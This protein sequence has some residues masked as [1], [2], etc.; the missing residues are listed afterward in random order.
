MRGIRLVLISVGLLCC[1]SVCAQKVDV[2]GGFLTDSIKI[3]EE[4]AFYLSARYPSQLNVLFPDSSYAFA[5]FEY[6]RKVYFPTATSGAT[7]VDSAVYYVSTFEIDRIQTLSLPAF[8][9]NPGDCTAVHSDT[10]TVLIVQLVT[11]PPD[12]I[13]A[14]KPPLKETLAYQEVTYDFNYPLFAII[15]GSVLLVVVI[16]LLIFG[17]RIRRYYRLKR[18]QKDHTKFQESYT[19]AVRNLQQVFSVPLTES[20]LVVWKKYMEQL[21]GKPYTKLTTREMMSLE[22]DDVL[23]KN[24][25]SIDKALYGHDTTVME[26]LESL[27][28]FADQRFRKKLEEVKHG[29]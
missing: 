24:L 5:P 2:R 17:K 18:L 6:S 22:P 8:V 10:D 26:S 16:L 15:G 28:G 9:V 27:K 4:T 13:T 29:A 11:V 21:D 12:S 20:A 14:E 1:L 25:K 19:S 3:G 23:G 7:S